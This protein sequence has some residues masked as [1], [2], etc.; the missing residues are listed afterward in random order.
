MNPAG[1]VLEG[2]AFGKAFRG[3]PEML[4]RDVFRGHTVIDGSFLLSAKQEQPG[5]LVEA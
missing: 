4:S 1:G 5:E 2:F 3:G